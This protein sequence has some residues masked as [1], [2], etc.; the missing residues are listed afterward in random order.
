MR[1]RFTKNKH[2]L[3]RECFYLFFIAVIT[4]FPKTTLDGGGQLK[5]KKNSVK[6]YCMQ[7]FF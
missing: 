3:P 5:N 7:F 6:D 1:T 2:P 4:V